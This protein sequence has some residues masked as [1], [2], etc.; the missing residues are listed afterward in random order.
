MRKVKSAE[1]L[2]GLACMAVVLSHLTLIFYPQLH[3]FYK[4]S[5]P[6]NNILYIIHNSPFAFFIQGQALCLFFS[7]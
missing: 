3:D 7:A 5:L 4:S 2:R 1:A 6:K